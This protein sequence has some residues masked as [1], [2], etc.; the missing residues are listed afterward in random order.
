MCSLFEK[1]EKD[2]NFCIVWSRPIIR[3]SLLTFVR[4]D[5]VILLQADSFGICLQYIFV[6]GVDMKLIKNDMNECVKSILYYK[7]H[8]F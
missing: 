3:H 4:S 1:K 7:M 2:G 5:L 6:K 8:V